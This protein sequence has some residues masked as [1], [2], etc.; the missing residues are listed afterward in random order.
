MA[1]SQILLPLSHAVRRAPGALICLRWLFIFSKFPS[2]RCRIYPGRRTLW[3][4]VAG[5]ENYADTVWHCKSTASSPLPLSS[6]FK[7]RFSRVPSAPSPLHE[8]EKKKKKECRRETM[9]LLLSI[10]QFSL[11]SFFLLEVSSPPLPIPTLLSVSSAVPS[12][13]NHATLY[14]LIC[15]SLLLFLLFH[16]LQQW[17]PGVSLDAVFRYIG[18]SD[19]NSHAGSTQHAVWECYFLEY[20]SRNE[21]MTNHRLRN[22]LLAQFKARFLRKYT[23]NPVENG[24]KCGIPNLQ[25]FIHQ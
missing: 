18:R 7:M 2:Q 17:H 6:V 14:D 13:Q 8:E 23:N 21:L 10:L 5:V 3:F 15:S 24:K 22:S 4:M 16:K 19:I 9:S 25:I 1:E 20:V 11:R 12:K